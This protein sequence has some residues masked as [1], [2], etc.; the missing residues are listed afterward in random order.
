[1]ADAGIRVVMV[2]GVTDSSI[3]GGSQG[4]KRASNSCPAPTVSFLI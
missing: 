2:S 1:M 3:A 4:S